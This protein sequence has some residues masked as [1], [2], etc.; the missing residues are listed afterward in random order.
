MEFPW[1]DSETASAQHLKIVQ[2]AIAHR[3]GQYIDAPEDNKIEMLRATI[4]QVEGIS[5][6]GSHL[7]ITGGFVIN[8]KELIYSMIDSLS[9]SVS[10]QYDGPTINWQ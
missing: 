8:S 3:N 9:H 5:F 7:T 1:T 10:K 2:D 4:K 6:V